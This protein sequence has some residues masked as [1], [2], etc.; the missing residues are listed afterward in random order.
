MRHRAVLVIIMVAIAGVLIWGAWHLEE[1]QEPVETRVLDES[2]DE[3]R[4]TLEM[5]ESHGGEYILQCTE[6]RFEKPFDELASFVGIHTEALLAPGGPMVLAWADYDVPEELRS[7]HEVV[8]TFLRQY[9][10]ERVVLVSHSECVY[11]DGIASV[12]G[13]ENVEDRQ[14]RDL[15]SARQTIERWLPGTKVELYF[16]KKEGSRLIFSRIDEDRP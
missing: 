15:Q 11:Y 9:S 2:K 10:P 5:K 3:G 16:G 8:R 4:L 12:I 1:E 7:A 6:D 13:D 14:L